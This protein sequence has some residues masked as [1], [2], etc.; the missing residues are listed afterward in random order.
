MDPE[1]KCFNDIKQTD[2]D[3]M[4]SNRSWKWFRIQIG[5]TPPL[6]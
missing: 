6:E 3:C 2:L 4:Y 5:F 1:V